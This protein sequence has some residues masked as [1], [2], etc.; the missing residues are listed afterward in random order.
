[1]WNYDTESQEYV[2][3]KNKSNAIMSASGKS[4]E[5]QRHSIVYRRSSRLG[6]RE[7]FQIL[8]IETAGTAT[9][10]AGAW[11]VKSLSTGKENDGVISYHYSMAETPRMLGC[12]LFY[13]IFCCLCLICCCLCLA[14]LFVDLQRKEYIAP[15]VGQTVYIVD[16][17]LEENLDNPPCINRKD[18]VWTIADW[19]RWTKHGYWEVLLIARSQRNVDNEVID[20]PI[21]TRVPLCFI[22]FDNTQRGDIDFEFKDLSPNEMKQEWKWNV[23]TENSSNNNNTNKNKNQE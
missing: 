22:V 1:M 11:N 14:F 23:M 15:K 10:G 16:D 13:D 5:V 18:L 19:G 6:K 9:C 4:G 20:V 17:H 21:C 7:K 2:F 3:F 12:V 8:D